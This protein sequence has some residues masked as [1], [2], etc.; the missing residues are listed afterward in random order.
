MGSSFPKNQ[1]SLRKNRNAPFRSFR[2]PFR[3]EKV[4]HD[5]AAIREQEGK[6]GER[7]ACHRPDRRRFPRLLPVE[8]HPVL[9][10]KRERAGAVVHLPGLPVPRRRRPLALQAHP[11]GA[12]PI[13][14][15]VP[16]GRLRGR[17]AARHPRGRP[18]A[19]KTRATVN[20]RNCADAPQAERLARRADRFALGRVFLRG[21]RA[22]RRRDHLAR[23]QDTRPPGPH[24]RTVSRRKRRSKGRAQRC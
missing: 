21:G 9:Y 18:A 17:R 2:N 1:V 6:G 22:V 5:P 7:A 19:G 24:H 11:G 10:R 15:S 16:E 13:R 8:P 20:Q 23:R 12:R 14:W 3:K 4:S